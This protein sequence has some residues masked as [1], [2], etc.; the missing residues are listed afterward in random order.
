MKLQETIRNNHKFAGI[1]AGIFLL[2][3]GVK[4]HVEDSETFDVPKP[5]LGGKVMLSRYHNRGAFLNAGEKKSALVR[6]M[7]VALTAAV[8]L[9]F[10]VSLGQKGNGLLKTGLAFL[11]GGAFSNTYDR[12]SRKYVVD[13]M[14]LR[15]GVQAVDR[16]VFNF[17]DM[18]ILIGALI[19]LFTY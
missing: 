11:L 13:Y 5:V 6:G 19:L 8:L 18:C 9:L 17:A 1:A 4:N 12:L 3:E 10:I 15:T 14:S 2:D 16:V 7:S